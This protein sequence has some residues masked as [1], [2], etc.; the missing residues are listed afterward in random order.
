[1]KEIERTMGSATRI[2]LILVFLLVAAAAVSAQAPQ[3]ASSTTTTTTTG[4]HDVATDARNRQEARDAFIR[5]MGQHPPELTRILVLD[6]TLLS[7]DPFLA[8]YPELARFLA[9][10]PEVRRNP[11]YYLRDFGSPNEYRRSVADRAVEGVTI[12]FVFLLMTFALGW[13]VRTFIE[14]KR[15]T[16]LSRTQSEVHNKILDRFG[17][18]AELL[19][20]IQSPAGTKFLE[21]APIPLHTEPER[22]NAPLAR[23]MWSIQIGLIVA[24]GG[25]G[26]LLVSGR[27][28]SDSNQTLFAMGTI[29]LC[30]GAG[31]IVS[32]M[33]SVFVSRR[34]GLLKDTR[35]GLPAVI[36]GSE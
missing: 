6:P 14:Q 19:E 13:F 17:S 27:F 30:I 2:I 26:L 1:V 31:F 7:N 4:T 25:L 11:H 29:A 18:G 12:G 23:V 35:G 24:A 28:A 36:D 10:H 33:V 8:R 9:D 20:Y 15:W 22:L 16:Q 21:S 34:F 32:A 3:T 5:L